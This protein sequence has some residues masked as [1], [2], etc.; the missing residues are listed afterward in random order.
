MTSNHNGPEQYAS[1]AVDPGLVDQGL[2]QV[3]YQDDRYELRVRDV[4]RLLRDAGMQ[5]YVV[6]GAPR[7]WLCGRAARDID[8]SLDR[9]VEEAHRVLRE[10]FPDIDPV[11]LRFERFGMLRW[12]NVTGSELDL[13]IL[14]SPKD[15]QGDSMWNTTFVARQ[16]L[17]EDAL[18]RD[19]SVNAF[20]YPCPGEPAVLDPLGCGLDDVHGRVL[21]VITHRRVLDTSAR[22]TFRITQFLC[23]GYVATPGVLEHLEHHA[24]RDVQMMGARSTSWLQAHLGDAPGLLDE[25]RRRIYASVRQDESHRILDAAFASAAMARETAPS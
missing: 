5:L 19:F 6:G 7:D 12:G 16:D 10:A 3:V 23:R 4:V 17:R 21:R 8:I 22:M 13:N 20:Y 1:H 9:P 15:I 2:A 24:D 25:F 14:R 11:P 18:T